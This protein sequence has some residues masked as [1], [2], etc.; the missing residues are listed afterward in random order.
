MIKIIANVLIFIGISLF[1]FIGY[2]QY[3]AHQEKV[4][5]I[6]QIIQLQDKPSTPGLKEN[7]SGKNQKTN[8]I[9]QLEIS[10]INLKESIFEGT[11]ED[12]LRVA[13]GHLEQS[14]ELG[15]IGDNFV[16]LGHRNYITGQ[17]FSRLDEL[18]SGD[19]MTIS[20]QNKVYF[21]RVIQK[22]II[23]PTDIKAIRPIPNKSLVTLITCHPKFSSKQRLLVISELVKQVPS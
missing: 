18:D 10:K 5:M 7:P 23:D 1:G 13:V 11:S 14:G 22:K 19:E 16:V 8:G 20:T 15:K 17:Y 12:I 3:S 2:E 4:K 9:P 21:Y 6:Q